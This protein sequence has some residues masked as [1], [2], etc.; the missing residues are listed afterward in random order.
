MASNPPPGSIQ[1]TVRGSLSW[2]SERALPAPISQVRA[3]SGKL[4]ARPCGVYDVLSGCI[5]TRT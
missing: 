1:L 3:M 2:T 4:K 5:L